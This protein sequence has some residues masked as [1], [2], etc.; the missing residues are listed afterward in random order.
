MK[1]GKRTFSACANAPLPEH[2]CGHSVWPTRPNHGEKAARGGADEPQ[3]KM[4]LKVTAGSAVESL[5][6]VFVS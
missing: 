1:G 2:G 5:N 3:P 6:Q 4:S